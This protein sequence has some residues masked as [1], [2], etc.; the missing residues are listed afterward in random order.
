MHLEGQLCVKRIN[1]GTHKEKQYIFHLYTHIYNTYMHLWVCISLTILHKYIFIRHTMVCTYQNAL[2]I[3]EIIWKIDQFPYSL[4]IWHNIIYF[5]YRGKWPIFQYLY[6]CVISLQTFYKRNIWQILNSFQMSDVQTLWYM[7]DLQSL[8]HFPYF[9]YFASG[10]EFA[11]ETL[12][13]RMKCWVSKM[14]KL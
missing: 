6:I 9:E 4:V 8:R 1:K 2:K 14:K 10:L 3:L 12:S 11:I 7:N 5:K 13:I